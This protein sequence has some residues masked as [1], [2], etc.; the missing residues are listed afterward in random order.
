MDRVEV[1]IVSALLMEGEEGEIR[2][3]ETRICVITSNLYKDFF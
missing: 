1:F 3:R 2:H